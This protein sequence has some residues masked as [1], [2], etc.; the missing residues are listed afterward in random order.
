MTRNRFLPLTFSWVKMLAKISAKANVTM[1]TTTTSRMVFCMER[2]N[3][4][5]LS[6][7]LKL[8]RPTKVSVGE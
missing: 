8:L 2:I 4:V 5:S 6:S 1:V 3:R 7:A